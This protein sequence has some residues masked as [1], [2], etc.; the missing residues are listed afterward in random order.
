MASRNHHVPVHRVQGPEL[1]QHEEQED[2]DRASRIE[3][4]LSEV[5]QASGAQGNQVSWLEGPGQAVPCQ[6]NRGA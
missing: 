6:W 3:K 5:P 2:D 4:V 1:Q